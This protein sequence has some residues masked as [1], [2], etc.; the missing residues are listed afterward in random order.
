[1][2]PHQYLERLAVNHY[3][4]RTAVVCG[5]HSL[6][7]RELRD[8]ARAVA[9]GLGTHGI[10]RGDVG[11]VLLD[12]SVEFAV[13]YFA[14]SYL[15]ALFMP[16]DSRLATAEIARLCD[17]AEPSFLIAD[18]K[19]AETV[20]SVLKSLSR[21]RAVVSV[22]QQKLL[23]TD[24]PWFELDEAEHLF[25][26]VRVEDV[27]IDE[28]DP[29]ALLATSGTT[30]H[31]KLA[32]LP[33]RAW[34]LFPYALEKYWSVKADCAGVLPV[35]M[36]H[37]SGPIFLNACVYFPMKLV[38][39]KRYSPRRLFELVHEHA[40][41]FCNITP[42]MSRVLLD[43]LG[44]DELREIGSTSNVAVFGAP[45]TQ[46][47][48]DE[49]RE[50]MGVLP[51]SGYGLT[52]A[53]PLTCVTSLA[54]GV[55]KLGSLGK[56]VS[57]P[58]HKVRVVD[59]HG[60]DVRT[61]EIGEI[62]VSGPSLMLGYY[63]D[64]AATAAVLRDGWLYTGDLGRFDEEGYLYIAGRKKDI[65]FVHGFNV[66]PAEVESVLAS[67][68]AVSQAA[69]IAEQHPRS[70]E[71]VVAYVVCSENANVTENELI[72]YAR[73]KLAE[74]KVP[75]KILFLADMPKTNSGKIARDAL[76]QM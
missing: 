68:P 59:Q 72:E 3:A 47:H 32:M 34:D 66:L 24:I 56:P 49:F 9:A 44:S 29:L 12:N 73:H 57:M 61:G 54:T 6:T 25:A 42:S 64:D 60:D 70:G 5:R 38:I 14:C 10:G 16:I 23:P 40:P 63:K 26:D 15:G 21:C 31:P 75:R 11:L 46:T 53:A 27:H 2:I 62:L 8:K 35:P 43:R 52:E 69:V 55:H 30:G 4:D 7:Y 13:C 48:L 76:R 41:L 50:K 33:A 39:M 74:Y 17:I 67:H 20:G 37:I 19:N 58:G 71:C 1:M 22:G 45:M 28:Q 18:E 51:Q 36:S 65:I